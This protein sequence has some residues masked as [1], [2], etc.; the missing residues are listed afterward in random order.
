MSGMPQ[1]LRMSKMRGKDKH[2]KKN[3]VVVFAISVS[4]KPVTY[5]FCEMHP[6]HSDYP[7]QEITVQD[8]NT[9]APK[10]RNM[11]ASER[12]GTLEFKCV[13]PDNPPGAL[14]ICSLQKK[15]QWFYPNKN[16]LKRRYLFP[17]IQLFFKF[18][19]VK[20]QVQ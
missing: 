8:C 16:P 12:S 9:A 2:P 1:A 20:V 18:D 4:H 6:H 14:H 11:I 15:W 7:G 3:G 5:C 17:Q 10:H 19:F 13:D